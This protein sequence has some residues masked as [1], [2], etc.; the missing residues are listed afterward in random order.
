MKAILATF[1]CIFAWWQYVLKWD[2]NI[3]LKTWV[4]RVFL[5]L[6]WLLL[7][8][9]AKTYSKIYN[10]L[11]TLKCIIINDMLP[12]VLFYFVI[13]VAFTCAIQLQFR[14]LSV[15][16]ITKCEDLMGLETIF[17]NLDKVIYELIVATTRLDTDL[18]NVQIISDLFHDDNQ[19]STFIRLLLIAY[20]ILSV[21]VLLNMLIAMMGTTMSVVMQEEG[22]GWRQYQVNV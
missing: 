20:A 1:F 17:N 21:I 6:G 14:M 19:N 11:S 15:N 13:T 3:E 10:F 9:P 18:K 8:V 4:K 12:F 2:E 16:S 7:F 5:L 22:T